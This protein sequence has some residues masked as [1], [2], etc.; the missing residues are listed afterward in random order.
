MSIVFQ[1]E[2]TTFQAGDLL[3]NISHQGILGSNLSGTESLTPTF[4]T[5]STGSSLGH[6]HYTEDVTNA[7][8]FLN[9]SGSGEVSIG[10]LS[11]LV[12]DIVGFE[13]A[14]IFNNSNTLN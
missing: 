7:L 3:G 2:D 5:T 8:Q 12:A 14:I 13:G 10:E 6:Y 4:P 11:H 9:V 1:Q